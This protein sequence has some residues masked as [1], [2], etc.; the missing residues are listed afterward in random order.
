MIYNSGTGLM[1]RLSALEIKKMRIEIMTEA[2][3]LMGL[4]LH[5]PLD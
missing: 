4:Q 1:P 3:S 2:F 5:N